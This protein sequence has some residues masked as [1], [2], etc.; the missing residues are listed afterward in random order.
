MEIN[1]CCGIGNQA[2]VCIV[3]L[4]VYLMLTMWLHFANSILAQG[5]FSVVNTPLCSFSLCPSVEEGKIT[6]KSSAYDP[7]STSYMM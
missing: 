4:K 2:M 5:L 6:Y 7:K 3:N 1:L